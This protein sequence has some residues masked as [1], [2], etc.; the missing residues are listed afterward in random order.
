MNLLRFRL[1]ELEHLTPSIS[2]KSA[3][4]STLEEVPEAWRKQPSLV[5]DV[6][7]EYFDH[8][9]ASRASCCLRM[10]EAENEMAEYC[11]VDR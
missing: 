11:N 4:A 3:S 8:I 5:D 6:V 2:P 10:E 9:E 1:I 7:Q